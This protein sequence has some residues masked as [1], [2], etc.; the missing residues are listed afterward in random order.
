MVEVPSANTPESNRSQSTRGESQ[1]QQQ[2]QRFDTKPRPRFTTSPIP[3][4]VDGPVLSL[5]LCVGGVFRSNA[6]VTSWDTDDKKENTNYNKERSFIR[7]VSEELADDPD[8]CEGHAVNHMGECRMVRGLTQKCM[9]AWWV[10]VKKW[11]TIEEASCRLRYR[12]QRSWLACLR[13]CPCTHPPPLLFLLFLSLSVEFAR[14]EIS[15]VSKH[16][17]AYPIT[18]SGLIKLTSS[19]VKDHL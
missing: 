11:C 19:C 8:T 6:Q 3:R 10:K 18:N 4:I 2:Q 17:W 1:Q 16:V 15:C 7:C 14:K 9:R 12:V 5:M 13:S